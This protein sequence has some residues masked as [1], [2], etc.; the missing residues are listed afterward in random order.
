MKILQLW[1][2][3][4]DFRSICIVFHDPHS[5]ATLDYQKKKKKKKFG[6]LDQDQTTPKS[7][8]KNLINISQGLAATLKQK[9][10]TFYKDSAQKHTII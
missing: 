10:K 5:L 8:S 4:L 6:H 2:N 3:R 1:T 9:Q 7:Y